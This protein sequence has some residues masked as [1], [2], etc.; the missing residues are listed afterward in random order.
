FLAE[1]LRLNGLAPMK[2]RHGLWGTVDADASHATATGTDAAHATQPI[3]PRP[4]AT[5][6]ELSA[7]NDGSVAV[8]GQFDLI[9]GSDILYERDDTGGLAQFI[10]A[11]A[12]ASAEVW[13][14]DPNRGNRPAFNRRMAHMGFA[15][16]E[17]RLD[18]VANPTQ[19]AYKGRLLTY[20]RKVPMH[21]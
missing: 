6:N 20:L 3:A 18:H 13:I 11:H 5:S 7:R 8:S 19:G 4:A 17:V 1:N 21:A 15:L 10:E 14:V 16:T 12:A 2:Y 9:M